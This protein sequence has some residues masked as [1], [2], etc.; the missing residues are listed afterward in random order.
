MRYLKFFVLVLLFVLSM[1]FFVQNNG[2]LST[3]VQLELN[4]VVA[5]FYSLPLPVYVLVLLGFLVGALLSLACFLVERIRLGLELKSLRTRA[6]ALEDELLSLRTQ[7]LGQ[8][9]GATGQ[10]AAPGQ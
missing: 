6:S 3:V 4:L 2:P 8:S 7:P 1:F 9:S 5:R 10:S